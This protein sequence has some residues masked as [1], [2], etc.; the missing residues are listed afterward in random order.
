MHALP[1][2]HEPITQIRMLIQ[3]MFLPAKS[4][5]VF[6]LAFFQ[7]DLVQRRRGQFEYGFKHD[8]RRRAAEVE[9]GIGH[10]GPRRVGAD[11]VHKVVG[12]HPREHALVTSVH[13]HDR[14][15]RRQ[16]ERVRAAQVP[17]HGL[18]NLS[19]LSGAQQAQPSRRLDRDGRAPAERFGHRAH[20]DVEQ[21][22][23]ALRRFV[24]S[25]RESGQTRLL[26]HERLVLVDRRW[27][28]VVELVDV[29][30]RARRACVD[31]E[32]VLH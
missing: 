6:M 28:A 4:K 9:H 24:R 22:V 26:L 13:D 12:R 14:V 10:G 23:E 31:H 11:G 2:P 25:S 29:D 5:L 16:R 21:R 30:A 32:R 20:R 1:R 3:H 15:L 8:L 19:G 18:E 7:R 27:S 17:P